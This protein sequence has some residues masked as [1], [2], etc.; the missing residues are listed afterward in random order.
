MG[1]WSRIKE[2][3]DTVFF[4]A[5]F[6]DCRNCDQLMIYLGRL[7]VTPASRDAGAGGCESSCEP[8]LSFSPPYPVVWPTSF[9]YLR[10]LPTYEY[11]ARHWLLDVVSGH[12]R[13]IFPIFSIICHYLT[14]KPHGSVIWSCFDPI[15][16]V[17]TVHLLTF[18]IG[19]RSSTAST[20][21]PCLIPH[22]TCCVQK[23]PVIASLHDHPQITELVFC[24]CRHLLSFVSLANLV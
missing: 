17:L 10:H 7:T 23:W 20:P 14:F 13:P 1:F 5:W 4:F 6:V 3:Q 24:M 21:V 12:P 8:M 18:F 2:H 19:K 11:L 22:L 9:T 15:I 16:H